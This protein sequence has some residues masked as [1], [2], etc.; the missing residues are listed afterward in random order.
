M[1]TLIR[2]HIPSGSEPP[3]DDDPTGVRDLLSSLPEPEPMPKHLV[4]RINASLAAEQA[5]RTSPVSGDEVTPLR[6]R[7]RIRRSRMALA[8]AGAAAGVAAIGLVGSSVLTARQGDTAA[9]TAA[10]VGARAKSDVMQPSA[11]DKSQPLAGPAATPAVLQIVLSGTRYTRAGFVA[12]VETLRLSANGQPPR[13]P[14]PNQGST[15]GPA[16]TTAGLRDCLDAIGA[17]GAETV[18]ADVA[19][20]EGQP[21]V[22]IVA[23]TKGV[24]TAYAV[25]RQCSGTD[26]AVLRPATPLP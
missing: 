12:Q 8:L 1:N 4:E 20:Y 5:Q 23:T 10:S 19:T 9:S 22:I 24:P 26:A 13:Q 17:G 2:P 6:A 18:R 3:R 21:A 25:G 14:E 16:G 11:T 15:L 7:P